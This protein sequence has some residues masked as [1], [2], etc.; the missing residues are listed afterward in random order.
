MTKNIIIVDQN[1]QNIQKIIN[2]SVNR[3]HIQNIKTFV[4]TNKKQIKEIEKTNDISLILINKNLNY[5]YY[6]KDCPIFYYRR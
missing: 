4:A 1:I 2:I 3:I 6:K 5:K